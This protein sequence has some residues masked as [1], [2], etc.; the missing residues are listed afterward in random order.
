MGAERADRIE[1]PCDLARPALREPSWQAIRGCGSGPNAL[2]AFAVF[3]GKLAGTRDFVIGSAAGAIAVALDPTEAF[4]AACARVVDTAPVA[5]AAS[6]DPA[7]HPLY[8][9][10]FG[11]GDPLGDLHL[12][13][14]GATYTLFYDARL[15]SPARAALLARAFDR[16]LA[17]DAATV[18]Q[19]S[20]LGAADEAELVSELSSPLFNWPQ[21]FVLHELF[22]AW[23]DRAPDATA[24]VFGEQRITYA[25]LDARANAVAQQLIDRGV[26]ADSIVALICDRSIEMIVAII[27]ALKAGG[28]YLP[29]E[30]DAPADRVRYVL[31]DSRAAAVLTHSHY[32][33]QIDHAHV[34]AVDQLPKSAPRPPRRSSPE[35]LAYVIYTSG[36]TGKPKGVLIEH[37]NVVHLVFAEKEDFGIRASDALILLSSYSFDA[38][39]DQIWL[40]LTSGAKLVL[41]AKQSLLDPAYLSQLIAAER[42]THLDS[43]PALLGELSPMLSSVRQVVVG[44]ET[45]PVTVAR[46]WSRTTRFWNEYGP[47]ETTVGSLRHLVDPSVDLGARVPIGRPI[48]LN[49]VYVLDW[50]G[51]PVPIGVRGELF[52]GGAGV[53]RGYLNR[54]ELTRERFVADP[55]AGGRMYKTGDVVAWLPDG[56]IEFFGRI[57]SQV[58]VRGFRIE[59]GE[60]EAALEKHAE[61]AGAAASVMNDRLVAHFV[62]SRSIDA[63]E[64]RA[65][66][67]ATLPAYMV[68][69]AFVQ[70]SAF[71]RNVSGKIDRKALPAPVLE[72]GNVEAPANQIEREV[73][74]IW[75]ALLALPEDHISVTRSFFELGG[76]SLLVMK[77]LARIR[78]KLGVA[79]AAQYVLAHP[80]IRE[81]ADAI[82]AKPTHGALARSAAIDAMPATNV[83]RRMYVIHQGAPFNTS[84]NLPLLY[85]VDGAFDIAALERACQALVARHEAL[86]TAFF[87]HEGE[88]IQKIAAAPK[89]QLE[90]YDHDGDVAVPAGKFVR[91]F[92]LDHPPLFRVA[93]FVRGGEVT[94]LALDMHHI[95]SD[96]ISIDVLLEDLLALV[97]GATLVKPDARYFDYAAWLGTDDAKQRQ[98]AGHAYWAK[99]LRDEPPV[100]DLPYDFR[101]PL[102]RNQAA[103]ELSLELRPELVERIAKLAREREATPFAFFAA[104]YSAFLSCMTGSADVIWGFPSA[105]R[106]HPELETVVGMFVNT[107]VFR[108]KLERAQTFDELLRASMRQIVESLRN[109]DTPFEEMVDEMR[110]PAPGR[111]PI[112]DTMLSYEGKMA[113]EYR[114][115]DAVLREQQL[116]H[117]FART[118]LAV[119]VRERSRGGYWLRLEYSADLFKRAT[120]ERLAREFVAMIE[121]VVAEPSIALADLHAID[122]DQLLRGFNATAHALPDVSSVHALW[123][124]RVA[125]QP[126]AIA[127]EMGHAS[128]TYR[129]VD[130]R[131]HAIAHALRERGIGRESIVGILLEPCMEMLVSVLGVMTAGAAFLPIDPAYPAARKAH[132]LADSG[133]R[134]LLTHGALGRDF[135]IDSIDVTEIVVGPRVD[136]AIDA[137]DLAYVIYTSG[138]TGVPKGTLIEHHSLLNFACWYASYFAIAAGDGISKFAGFGFDASIS[139]IVPAFVAGA[140]LVIVPTETRLAIDELDAY[141]QDHRVDVAFL[142]TQYGEQFL[143]DAYRHSLRAAFLGGEK[144]RARP[145]ERCTIVNGYGPTEYTVAA[146]AFRV[147][148]SYD[149]IPIGAP[150]W[151]TQVLVL[152]RMGRLS[153]IGVPGE[154]CISGASIARG[155][156]KRPDQDADKFVANPYAPGERMYRTGD[157]ARWLAD[158]N[159]EFLGRIDTQVKVRGF[160]VELGEIEQALLAM[161]GID[162]ATVVALENPAVPGDLALVAYVEVSGTTQAAT[163]G[164][165][166]LAL[167]DSLPAYMVPSRIVKIDRIP[168]TANGKVDKH[169]LPVVEVDN[170]PV[171]E[172]RDAREAELR[173]LY[174]E[175]LG[176]P[177]AAI[178][179]DRS[180]LELGGHSLKAAALLSAIFK[181]TGLQLKL[182]EFLAH[183][184]I[185]EV[186]PKLA[187]TATA[188]AHV[189]PTAPHGQ[190]LALTSAQLRIYAVHQLSTWSTAY[191][192]PFAWQL[193]PDVDLARLAAAL[194]ML[195]ARH[196]AL[197]MAI[198]ADA[199]GIPHQRFGDATLELA[200]IA[201]EDANLGITLDRFVQPFDFA[202]APLVRAGII[203]TERRTVLVLDVHHIAADGLS[204]RVMLDELEQ[205]YA[206][207]VLPPPSPTFAD[208]AMWETSDA[209]R[210]ERDAERAW[211]LAKFAELP[212]PLELPCDRDRPP[213]LS[214]EGDD[215]SF[216]LP[217]EMAAPLL[218]LA[219][220][221]GITPLG[222]LLAAWSVVLSRIGNT[223]DL[224]IG[225][226][227]SGR[228]HRGMEQLVGMFVNTVPL[229]MKLTA[230]EAFATLCARV[231]REANEAFERQSYHLSDLV[232]DLNVSRDPARNPLFDVLFAWQ[233]AELA[234]EMASPLGLTELP[235]AHVESKFDLELT[236]QQ[237]SKGLHVNLIFATQLFRQA[238]AEKFLGYLRGVLEQA[239][240]DPMARVRDFGMLQ[241]WERETLLEDF[242]P[243]A[244][245]IAPATLVDVLARHVR[246]R[247]DAIAVLD[248]HGAYSYAELD[249]R[250]S[251]LAERLVARGVQPDDVVALAVPRSRDM[252]VAIFGVMKAGAGY[253]PIEPEGHGAPVDRVAGIIADS[254]A[255]LLVADGTDFGLAE[256][257]HWRDID[258]TATPRDRSSRAKPEHV[259]YVIYTSGSTGKPKGVVIE[260]RNAVYYIETWAK[261]LDVRADDRVLLFASYTFDASIEQIGSALSAG[262]CVVVPTKDVLLDHDAF[263]AFVRDHGVTH[264]HAVPLFLSGFTPK[265]PLGLRRVIAAGDIC[266]LPVATRWAQLQPL[267]NAYGPTETTVISVAHR[268]TPDDF[269]RPR[270][271]IGKPLA[272]TKIFILDWTGNLAPIGVPGEM[273]IGGPGVSRGY[274][275]DPDRTRQRFIA[276]P[277]GD[278]ERLYH[279][280]D[281]ARWSAD[282]TLDFL[283][284]ADNQ[285]KIRG[286][287]IELGEIEAALLRHADVAEAA[288]IVVANGDDKR[289]CA[290]VVLKRP[291]DLRTFLARQLP[292]YMVPDSIVAMDA[293]PV[294]TSGKIDRKRLPEPVFEHASAADLPATL[295]EETL[296]EIWAAILK[297][298]PYQI[299]VTRSFFE[300]GG[301]SLLIMMMIARIQETFSVR[302]TAA[303]VF[304]RPT[305]RDLAALIEEHER[306]AIVPIPKASERGD[307]PLTA[308]QR[309]MFAIAQASPRST[310]YNIPTLFAVEGHVTPERLEQVVRALIARHASL[311]TSFHVV[312]GEPI[313]R[314]HPSVLFALQVVDSDAPIDELMDRF[315]QP[316]DLAIAPLWRVWHVRRSTGDELVVLDIH[317]II[318]DGTSMATILAE[319]ALYFKGVALEPPRIHVGDVALWQ[320]TAEHTAGLASQRAFWLEQFATVPPPLDLPYD[321]RPPALRSHDGGLAS[322]RLSKA[323]LDALG[324]LARDR[325][326][327]PFATV[328]AAWFVFLSRIGR[329]DDIVVGV[330]VSGRVHPDVQELVGMFVNTVPWRAQIPHAG[331]FDD[332]LRGTRATSLEVLASQEYELESLID[333]LGSRG[334]TPLF[335]VMFAYQTREDDVVDA[336][337]VKLRPLDFEHHTAKA[338]LMLTATESGDGLELTLEFASELFEAATAQ[339]L[340]GHFATLLR[341]VIANPA[342]PLAALELLTSGER[343]HLLIELNATEHALPPVETVLALFDDWVRATPDAPCVVLGNQVWS[344]REVDRRAN[345]IASWLL[346][347][348][349]A[350]DELVPII[351]NPC[352]EQLPAVLGVLKSG[353]A[354]LP[355]DIAYPIGR[356]LA[357]LADSGARV[358]LHRGSNANELDFAGPRLDIA[359]AGTRDAAPIVDVRRAHAA[360][361]IYTSGST[362]KPKGVVIEHG[363]LLNFTAWYNAYNAI[364]PGEALSKYAGPSF[365]TSISELFPACTTGGML[366]I[367]PAELRL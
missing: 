20:L 37:R 144:L 303:E 94:H 282:G 80:T 203:A 251:L 186:A 162:G 337:R 336:D 130:A 229:R 221:Q 271:P 28:A 72:T 3:V 197:R 78:E 126:D 288:V 289:L 21:H 315:V 206:G 151:N 224:V 192:I 322:S 71:P 44:G 283:G 29:I 293:F 179:V 86:R 139:E 88:I 183:S 199:D 47:T 119:I 168:L 316:F 260:H 148:K 131:A 24:L 31:E 232:T 76:H 358:L 263:E 135:A 16:V 136:V 360:Y 14:D 90:R 104:I 311:R 345:A 269:K 32:A 286:F 6:S 165:L 36:S 166:K 281:R 170:A 11:A 238:T 120:A 250:A 54:D 299:P 58:K 84:D 297:L 158:G 155:Y 273:F 305:V 30:P 93:V 190:A 40:S 323:E 296:V 23:V 97:R 128:L 109:E 329:S 123:Q 346:E 110:A 252:L 112:F 101:R 332:F 50:G 200:R 42:V 122:A 254:R 351:M 35:S 156:L 350:T 310:S 314:I 75:R 132:M 268:I 180:F 26:G 4:A 33:A 213:R 217:N 182:A 338:D 272:N 208:Y 61:L 118:D 245:A 115:G 53:A 328:L 276:S 175:V 15:F 244:P 178:S 326:S 106:P 129:E 95:I 285:I 362:G 259:A 140:R 247:P 143:R 184:S 41:V 327:T 55:F 355:I 157:L 177:A 243:N 196:D 51:R 172:P 62:A 138:S 234:E 142:P 147:D 306:S 137:S 46:A 347:R 79:L 99:L 257:L 274:L 320:T 241:P 301:H 312:K 324:G 10:G 349:V 348:G 152:D 343:D 201:I 103:G 227:A 235:A 59:L 185:A 363:S 298:A 74:A 265:Q 1:L 284:R 27:G 313:A 113:D 167:G 176:R 267:Y 117:R 237:T 228:Q 45:C 191:N 331:S 216:D 342:Q 82:A 34:L 154:L 39:I 340:I 364:E 290:Y 239:A 294:T 205:L 18:G 356:K 307:Y 92:E 48:G 17:S 8:D 253:L 277:F 214:F 202:R 278:G 325:A 354:F 73:R 210:A 116:P 2:G 246:D 361:V 161:P 56:S 225:V 105:G 81:I 194:Q 38:S 67:G 188:T 159:L 83:Q 219:K 133:A 198:T 108:T 230:D 204:V 308:V 7:R 77:M 357:I 121:R 256:A 367:V 275:N 171:A 49:R 309:R 266:P 64:L 68:P 218:E 153:P 211:W 291:V 150:V 249:R 173:E 187:T 43:V 87:F 334:R 319:V 195:V 189:W 96:G 365:D 70:M 125:S 174:A 107:L 169:K 215:V 25:E 264:L 102:T 98:L 181:R 280:G 111:N 193:A 124:A 317:H 304:A 19:V 366:V 353:A 12:V 262:A 255:R 321:F 212:S 223:P 145:T 127:V 231:G 91:P 335:E 302:L 258:W 13:V 339:R 209:G 279:T 164:D 89:F 242:N 318:A 236:V 160:R 222:V 65:F 341:S 100:L 240:H 226:P 63:S 52:L 66:L 248:A 287:R 333:E 69:E 220:T 292:A 114:C 300:L 57:D 163:E 85:K 134:V 149:N 270:V 233:D 60:I 261:Q 207:T 344:Y 330:P 295:A 22:E 146:T 5:I 9:V 352:A 141:F 359:T